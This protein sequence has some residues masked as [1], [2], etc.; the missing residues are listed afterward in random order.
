MQEAPAPSPLAVSAAELC[1]VC[2]RCVLT[3]PRSARAAPANEM[4]S[5]SATPSS[6]VPWQAIAMPVAVGHFERPASWQ[7]PLHVCSVTAALQPF[8][9]S[10]HATWAAATSTATRSVQR[11]AT[12]ASATPAQRTA[13]LAHVQLREPA[14]RRDHA[15]HSTYVP[16]LVQQPRVTR[17]LQR[18][19]R[20]HAP[21]TAPAP[22]AAPRVLERLLPPSVHLT[23]PRPTLV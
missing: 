5:A 7:R 23:R 6:A 11:F 10:E 12:S 8:R 15:L 9:M 1:A 19:C 22:G 18:H 13:A 21:G 17:Q 2:A 4:R 20:L 3:L 16:A 14:S